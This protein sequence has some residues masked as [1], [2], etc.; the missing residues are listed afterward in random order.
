MIQSGLKTKWLG[1]DLRSFSE[2]NST[3][4]VAKS[5]APSLPKRHRHSGRD[6]DARSRQT[7]PALGFP[8]GRNLDESHPQAR[9]AAGQGLPDKYGC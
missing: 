2:V 6:P 7:V 8:S 9:D 3:N 4:E 1:R 5:L